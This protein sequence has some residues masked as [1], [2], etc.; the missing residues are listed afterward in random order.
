MS[1]SH[2]SISVFDSSE[3]GM[4]ARFSDARLLILEPRKI[5]PPRV[6]ILSMN[7]ILLE[8]GDGVNKSGWTGDGRGGKCLVGVTDPCMEPA[9]IRQRNQRKYRILAA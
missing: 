1:C 7:G 4:I 9:K 5:L 6:D 3:K 8:F 2:Y